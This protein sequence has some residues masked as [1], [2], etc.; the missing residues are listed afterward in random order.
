[1]L[2]LLL[3]DELFLP[4]VVTAMAFFMA[5]ATSFS[6]FERTSEEELRLKSF[7]VSVR[8]YLPWVTHL[9]RTIRHLV[10]C[11]ILKK[12]FLVGCCFLKLIPISFFSLY[13]FVWRHD[14]Y[15]FAC[16]IHSLGSRERAQN[17]S[18]AE[19]G[20]QKETQPKTG[21]AVTLSEHFLAPSP[22]TQLG[23]PPALSIPMHCLS[24]RAL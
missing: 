9:P 23:Q 1:M 13:S 22:L 21:S 2:P 18:S 24:R 7:S 12:W 10:S 6:I 5:C 20:P 17:L 19:C 15:H 4:S 8:K 11:S 16:K 3:K 14:S